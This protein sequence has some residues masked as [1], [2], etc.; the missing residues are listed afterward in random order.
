MWKNPNRSIFVTVHKSP[1]IKD[2]HI[3][4]DTLSLIAERVG[5]GLELIGTGDKLPEKNSSSG[6][7]MNNK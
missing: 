2:L 7:K 6:T 1:W 3:K 4:Q 5:N